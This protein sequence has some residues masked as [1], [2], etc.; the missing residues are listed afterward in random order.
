MGPLRRLGCGKAQHP[1]LAI[2][3]TGDSP[4][5]RIATLAIVQNLPSPMSAESAIWCDILR[6]RRY[7]S[8]RLGRDESGCNERPDI[9]THHRSIDVAASHCEQLSVRSLSLV[10]N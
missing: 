9:R 5:H 7:G 4:V 2:G 1:N 8:I 10:S 6:R 3:R